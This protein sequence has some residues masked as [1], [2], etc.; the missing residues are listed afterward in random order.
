MG[1]R[2]RRADAPGE[3]DVVVSLLSD[4]EDALDITPEVVKRFRSESD[5]M[6]VPDDRAHAALVACGGDF[7]LAALS[8]AN[9]GEYGSPESEEDD[10]SDEFDF[11]EVLVHQAPTQAPRR[12]PFRRA[13]AQPAAPLTPS[14][15]RC[16]R[17]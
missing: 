7:A 17:R 6:D 5:L 13:A 15:S 10:D 1:T 8:F 4:D 3:L 12:V 16:V 2:K 9:A 14:P 11:S